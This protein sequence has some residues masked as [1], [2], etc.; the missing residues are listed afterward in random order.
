MNIKYNQNF[1]QNTG[2]QKKL[3]MTCKQK[4]SSQ[5]THVN[6]KQT[7]DQKTEGTREDTWRDFQMCVTGSGQQVAQLREN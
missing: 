3:Y 7:A 6:K 4:E 5:I 1:G 2:L